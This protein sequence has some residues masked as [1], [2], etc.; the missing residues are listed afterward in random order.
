MNS[1]EVLDVAIAAVSS[2]R[3]HVARLENRRT[4]NTAV[5]MT[6]AALWRL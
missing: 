2:R 6:C 1:V 3:E 5:S 4:R